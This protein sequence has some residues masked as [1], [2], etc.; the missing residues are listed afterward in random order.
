[1]LARLHNPQPGMPVYTVSQV[2]R[3]LKESLEQDS[4]LSDLWISGEVSNL[5]TAP[6]GHTYFTL[7]DH[8]SQ[9]RSVMFR[10]GRGG[11]LV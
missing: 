7:K 1:M 11:D 6:S 4:L 5:T 8:E 2:T 10:G 9:V 3:Y